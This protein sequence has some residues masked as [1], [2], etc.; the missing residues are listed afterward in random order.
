MKV[1]FCG[2]RRIVVTH[3]E[4]KHS[5]KTP[6]KFITKRTV[7]FTICRLILD[8]LVLCRIPVSA[9]EGD[10]RCSPPLLE[11]NPLTKTVN[12]LKY[13]CIILIAIYERK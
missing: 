6:P 11:S 7:Q 3:A 10:S 9:Q 12:N 5:R 13:L 8:I 4:H 2:I 1:D